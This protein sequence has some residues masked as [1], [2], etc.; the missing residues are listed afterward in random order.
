[1]KFPR[2]GTKPARNDFFSTGV[3]SGR[4]RAYRLLT[5]S[6]KT[7]IPEVK[8]QRKTLAKITLTRDR[9]IYPEGRDRE[10]LTA[11]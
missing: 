4:N 2:I 5:L 11:S 8:T 10:L 1:M 7:H 9:T 3:E 6:E